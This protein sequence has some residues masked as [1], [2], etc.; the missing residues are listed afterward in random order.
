VMAVTATN[1]IPRLDIC[2]DGLNIAMQF[3]HL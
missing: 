1:L 2:R 3:I